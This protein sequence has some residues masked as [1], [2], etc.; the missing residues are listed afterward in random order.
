MTIEIA[1]RSLDVL[2]EFFR[3]A[4]DK[5]RLAAEFGVN[6]TAKFARALASKEIR[7]EVNFKANYLNED[8]RLAVVK[9]AHG[10]DLE[11][12]IRGRDRPTSLARFA[13]STPH[14]GAQKAG[15]RVRVSTGGGSK[16][17]KNGFFMRLRRGNAQITAE[18]SNVGIAVRLKSGEKVRGKRS[19]VQVSKG[20]YLLYGPSVGQVFRTVAGD[21]VDTV[22]DKLQANF[23][24]HFERFTNGR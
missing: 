11:A 17:I 1:T 18:N 7:G 4:E 6:D 2:D 20:L 10:N 9:R 22:S 12:V 13:T 19:M 23:I 14:F 15:P 3:T 5:A 8:G 24:R 16:Q 21:I